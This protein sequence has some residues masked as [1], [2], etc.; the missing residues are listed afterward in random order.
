MQNHTNKSIDLNQALAM[1]SKAL[2]EQLGGQVLFKA[3]NEKTIAVHSNSMGGAFF[4]PL[5]VQN[6]INQNSNEAKSTAEKFEAELNSHLGLT[7]TEPA[8]NETKS[9]FESELNKYLGI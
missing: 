9:T 8:N 7:T 1:T 4:D 5:D 6:L 2:G 3:I